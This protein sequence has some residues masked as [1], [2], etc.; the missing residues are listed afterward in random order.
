MENTR[1]KSTSQSSELLLLAL[2][3]LALWVRSVSADAQP[4]S[5]AK[6]EERSIRSS[7]VEEIVVRARKRDEL[8][9]DTPV[10]VTAISAETLEQSGITRI[11]ELQTLIPNT[12]FQVGRNNQNT[13]LKMRGV[14]TG[15]NEIAFDP[16]VGVYVDGVFLPRALGALVELFDVSQIDVLRGPQGTLFGKNTI[17]GAILIRTQRPQENV[18]AS[19]SV[20]SGFLRDFTDLNSTTTRAVLNVPIYDDKVLSRF[21]FMSKNN[22]GYVADAGDPADKSNTNSYSFLGSLRFLP[23][24]SLTL[25]LSGSYSRDHNNGRGG[26]CVFFNESAP[27]RNVV[28]GFIEECM[29]SRPYSIHTDVNGI[30]DLE[31]TGVWGV[32]KWDAIENSAFDLS[33]KALGSWRRQHPRI[34]EDLDSTPFGIIQI[35]SIGG[36]PR[37]GEPGFQQQFNSEIQLT[38]TAWEDRA[39]VVSGLFGLWETA[40]FAPVTTAGGELRI[41]LSQSLTR[42]TIK[43]WS[44][45][46]YLQASVQPFEWLGV[47]FGGRFTE[48]NKGANVF[49]SPASGNPH[50]NGRASFERWTGMADLSLHV[51]ES[52][53][54][55]I[56]I[57]SWMTYYRFSQGFRG[58][59]FNA[60]LGQEGAT[61]LPGFRPEKLDSHEVGIKA[62]MLEKRLRLNLALFHGNYADIQVVT[63]RA[64]EDPT[65]PTGVRIDRLTQ[66]AAEATTQGIEL[67]FQALPL[68]GLN[69]TGSF[70]W[71]DATY[72]TFTEAADELRLCSTREFDQ[73]L[74]NRDRSGDGFD[75]VPRLEG[76]AS[77]H[78]A[79]P[80]KIAGHESLEG[81]LIPRISWSYRDSYHIFS[82]QVVPLIQRGYHLLNARL[83][84]HFLEDHLSVALW[85]KN[86]S[87]EAYF[88][89]GTPIQSS[90][91]SVTRYFNWP[92]TFGVEV[93]YD[94]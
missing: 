73:G 27:L 68:E 79:M 47:S 91:G 60:L 48:D 13:N 8:L 29:K 28:P 10:S 56:P 2:C 9:Q 25:D 6:E 21:S 81:L 34:N 43:N 71:I 31:S 86:L 64:T 61:T 18:A 36:S 92:R 20:R 55:D 32:A 46:G 37:N 88:N 58:G 49:I 42:S 69:L 75:R 59:G 16:G 17:G 53:L 52:W 5:A 11:D 50:R 84:Y 35:S 45:A 94:L 3:V 80:V 66:N 30:S 38:A 62:Q 90:F 12:F 85:A 40:R 44:M 67:E 93:R 1:W 57:E 19:L 87:D 82:R 65:G 83:G 7:H 70:G 39:S 41:P 72:D 15:S 33:V 63:I 4:A 74:C 89:E 76:A 14:G 77:L 24:D 23:S 51:P 54:N 22:E 26:Q 78:Y